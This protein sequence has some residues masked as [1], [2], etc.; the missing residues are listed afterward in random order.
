MKS[1]LPFLLLAAWPVLAQEKAPS[2]TDPEMAALEQEILDVALLNTMGVDLNY[3]DRCDPEEKALLLASVGYY[4]LDGDGQVEF[5]ELVSA[6]FGFRWALPF[7]IDRRAF[8]FNYRKQH[9]GP[10]QAKELRQAMASELALNASA[11][12]A[13]LA[14]RTGWR[15]ELQTELVKDEDHNRNGILDQDEL[16]MRGTWDHLLLVVF[17][18]RF[19][20]DFDLNGDGIL[21]KAERE[22]AISAI[23]ED[24]DLDGD[25]QVSL[26]ELQVLEQFPLFM[27]NRQTY[28]P[29]PSLALVKARYADFTKQY[30]PIYD[31][32]G[33]GR[34]QP[35]EIV[36][37]KSIEDR[38]SDYFTRLNPN[39][40]YTPEARDVLVRQLLTTRDLN[41][42]GKLEYAEIPMGIHWGVWPPEFGPETFDQLIGYR[43]AAAQPPLPP[44]FLERLNLPAY[45]LQR[46]SR[47]PDIPAAT[48]EHCRNSLLALY[49]SNHDGK[50]DAEEAW[51]A[52]TLEYFLRRSLYGKSKSFPLTF[53]QQQAWIA[54]MV[55]LYDENRD[56]RLNVAET[57]H[58]TAMERFWMTILFFN[59][60]A[61]RLDKNGDGW[62]DPD[63]RKPLE[64]ELMK[65]YDRNR[66]GFLDSKEQSAFWNEES[67]R[68]QFMQ[69]PMSPEDQAAWD[70]NRDLFDFDQDGVI[71]LW[72]LYSTSMI[73]DLGKKEKLT[74]QELLRWYDCL[75][76]DYDNNHDGRIDL[77]EANECK[78]W[79]LAWAALAP[80]RN[81][82]ATPASLPE[83]RQW[84][85][86]NGDANGDGKLS[87]KELTR[88]NYYQE[89]RV[90]ADRQASQ[91][92]FELEKID[93]AQ[94][95]LAQLFVVKTFIELM[96]S[97]EILYP[98]F[99][100]DANGGLTAEGRQTLAR[101]LL[102]T[103]DRNGDGSLDYAELCR[104]WRQSA[105]QAE[106]ARKMR[107]HEQLRR[108]KEAQD[109][110][111]LKKYDFNGNGKLEPEERARAAA[112]SKA[113]IQAPAQDE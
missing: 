56:G 83:L 10:L 6:N 41:G 98:D 104:L 58:L 111:L 88:L 67:Y 102:K 11:G 23:A 15:E 4:D 112:D 106:T 62:L 78:E 33:D 9:P 64:P 17:G 100:R 16:V 65:R 77:L 30:L 57:L 105:A 45:S 74:C 37:A 55:A 113:G 31:R 13:G 54:R 24:V 71:D 96:N 86:K 52:N 85:L 53:E 93:P 49:D 68:K 47:D 3:N 107:V 39:T 59:D 1:L 36:S 63:E 34:W 75:L 76:K 82:P 18:S 14:K 80:A 44:P 60:T 29:N 103:G 12:L 70:K 97:V 28:S 8:C 73:S 95:T 46:V 101:H 108:Q 5:L 22:A 51:I 50:L 109:A 90:S 38:L 32:N 48:L 84:A 79:S 99:A 42:N 21:N 40:P 43:L 110:E 35:R 27:W 87:L 91:W 94:P 66:N 26:N 20:D 89:L 7:S 61:R 19:T 81:L 2:A 25:G 72:L 69:Q 92:L